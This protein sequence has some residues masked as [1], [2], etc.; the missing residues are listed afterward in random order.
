ME[1][2]IRNLSK[3]YGK[4]KALS[5]VSFTLYEGVYGILGPN[6]AGKSTLINLITDNVR[7]ETGEILLDGQDISSLKLDYFNYI[8]YMPQEQGY[9]AE[10]SV[11]AFLMYVARLKGLKGKKIKQKTQ[12]LI[13]EFHLETFCHK[14]VGSLSGGMRQRVLLAQA[15]LNDPKILILDE[16]TAGV[17]PQERINIRNIISR[18]SKDRI[19]IIATHIV[20]DIEAIAKEIVIM[21]GGQVIK[22][23]TPNRLIKD[24][25]A[26]VKEIEITVEELEEVQKKYVISNIQHSDKGFVVRIICDDYKDNYLCSPS[27]ANLEDVY[28]YYF[29]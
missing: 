3:T 15:L 4:V 18:L 16:P 14:K 25:E 12:E 2:D 19:I 17:D 27:K 20:S 10:F 29:K 1:L 8:G 28:L 13:E 24:V 21:K 9:Y 26:R 23:E 6:G 22:K 11:R 7:R 5:N